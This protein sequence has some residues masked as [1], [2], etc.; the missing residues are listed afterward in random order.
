MR[1]FAKRIDI[2]H[3]DHVRAD[4]VQVSLFRVSC[5]KV[6]VLTILVL[7]ESWIKISLQYIIGLQ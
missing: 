4:D 3:H 1:V 2:D 7:P 5:L 6:L